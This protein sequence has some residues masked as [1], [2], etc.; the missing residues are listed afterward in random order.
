MK[1]QPTPAQLNATPSA[2]GSPSADAG[3]STGAR[4]FS[5]RT[6]LSTAAGAIISTETACTSKANSRVT[7]GVIGLGRRGNYVGAFMANHPNAQLAAICDVYDDKTEAGRRAIPGADKVPAY[8]DLHE[9]LARPD[10][11]AVLIATPVYLHPVHFEAAVKAK[12]HIYCEKPC[13]A[14]V[15]GVKVMQA[16]G[17]LADPSKTIQF[18][19]QQRFS[20]EYLRAESL[21]RQG[22]IGDMKLM[23]SYWILPNMLMEPFGQKLAP[24]DEKIRRWEFYRETSGCPIVEQDCHGVDAMNW[25]ARS[26]PLKAAGTGALRYPLMWGD[27]TAD[28]WNITYYYPGGIEGQLT[29]VKERLKV[30]YRDVREMFIGSDGCLETARWYYKHFG[31]GRKRA[32]PNDDDLRDRSLIERVDSKHEITIDAVDA[33]FRAIVDAKPVNMTQAATEST[34]TCLLGRM[35]Y[36]TKR[37]VTWEELLASEPGSSRTEVSRTDG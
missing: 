15:A 7:F 6:L 36:E 4:S 16:A 14:S 13:A 18:G 5:R 1:L 3:G 26:H 27:W 10:L 21:L 12:K 20:P 28:H 32:A 19:F 2:A 30:S 17:V 29:S 24:A 37:E 23:M 31:S 8:K 11:D 33:F 34:L 22:V 25:F 9:M 35:A